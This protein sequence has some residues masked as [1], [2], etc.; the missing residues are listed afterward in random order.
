MC[1]FCFH[2]CINSNNYLNK[3]M[4]IDKIWPPQNRNPQND[5]Q[6]NWDSWLYWWHNLQCRI[7][8][9]FAHGELLGK[10]VEYNTCQL[11]AVVVNIFRRASGWLATH[12]RVL[13][14]TCLNRRIFDHRVRRTEGDAVSPAVWVSMDA[15]RVQ[16][17]L[18]RTEL[19][20]LFRGLFK[21]L[22][23]ILLN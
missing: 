21:V 23:R 18:G 11:N 16:C 9:I 3:S 4:E 6:R 5:C 1:I 14:N 20:H 13:A 8:C 12:V 17:R 15:V 19:S 22:Y 7:S 10:C 2:L